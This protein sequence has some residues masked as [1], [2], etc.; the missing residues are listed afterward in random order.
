MIIYSIYV[1]NAS[2]LANNTNTETN[3]GFVL[4][5]KGYF[6]G[7]ISFLGGGE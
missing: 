2:P 4:F 5:F 7:G 3:S 1:A 6:G